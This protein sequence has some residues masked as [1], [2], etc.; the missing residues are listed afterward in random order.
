[1]ENG[2]SFVKKNVVKD[3]SFSFAIRIVNLYRYLVEKKSL[4]YPSSYFVLERP[5]AH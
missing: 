2:G 4:F 5:L 3:K 1:M